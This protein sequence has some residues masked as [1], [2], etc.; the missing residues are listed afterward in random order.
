MAPEVGYFALLLALFVSVAQSAMPFVAAHRRDLAITA[1][2]DQAALVQFIFVGIAFASLSYAFIATALWY[3]S[4]QPRP[5]PNGGWIA[6]PGSCICRI[7][8]LA[9]PRRRRRDW[10]ARRQ[11]CLGRAVLLPF[12]LAMGMDRGPYDGIWWVCFA[13][14]PAFASRCPATAPALC[15]HCASRIGGDQ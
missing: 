9:W 7:H 10:R 11:G 5:G 1:F 2:A 15:P 12:I 3:A 13:V 4:W 14:R 8:L 6:S